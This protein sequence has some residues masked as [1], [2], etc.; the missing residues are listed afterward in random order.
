MQLFWVA[1]YSYYA[2]IVLLTMVNC[3]CITL[4]WCGTCVSQDGC[5][6][7]RPP[8]KTRSLWCEGEL[9]SL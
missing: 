4:A 7:S 8:F 9:Q 6:T 1:K 2:V 5:P 3:V